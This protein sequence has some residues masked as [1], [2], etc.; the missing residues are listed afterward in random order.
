MDFSVEL[1]PKV[2]IILVLFKVILFK[3]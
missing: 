2:A 1:G 3:Y